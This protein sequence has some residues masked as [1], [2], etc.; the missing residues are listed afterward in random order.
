MLKT[1]PFCAVKSVFENKKVLIFKRIERY[2]TCPI[3]T[4][5]VA[6]VVGTSPAGT[7]DYH[8]YRQNSDGTWSHKQS[9]QPISN[10]DESDQLIYDPQTAD[11]GGYTE[12]LG[13]Y[14]VSPW[15]GYYDP[16]R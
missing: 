16:Y 4:Y 10:L 9:L 12:F 8:W 7:L 11:R 13:Y 6:L 1:I 15:N 14:A 5:K 2:D 3:G